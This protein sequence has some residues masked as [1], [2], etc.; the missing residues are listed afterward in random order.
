M[1]KA[2]E[3]EI[4]FRIGGAAELRRKL[5]RAGFRMVTPRTYEDNQLY[6]FPGA[7]L[8][9]RGE[10]LRL[11]QY[12]KAWKLTHKAKGNEGRHKSREET[13]TS[14]E[15]GKALAHILGRLGLQPSFRYEKYRT[16]YSDGR[17]HVV[18]D[19]TPLGAFGEIEGPARWI[20]RTAKTLGIAAAE[21][22]TDSYAQIFFSWKERS[23]SAAQNMTF[24]ECGRKPRR[25]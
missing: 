19:E 24:R 25:S 11:R 1:A 15:D 9:G 16:E 5:A 6:D 14:V 22:I 13:E 7:V 20:D 4:K 2:T 23:G 18:L 17:G 8:R 10:L 21:Y 12:G 3:V